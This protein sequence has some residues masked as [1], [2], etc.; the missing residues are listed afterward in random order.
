MNKWEKFF[1][2][3]HCLKKNILAVVK[4]LR[5]LLIQVTS[6]VEEFGKNLK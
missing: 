6:T 5:R 4:R 1:I 2:R 3:N